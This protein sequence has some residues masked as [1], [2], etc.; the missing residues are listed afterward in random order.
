MEACEVFRLFVNKAVVV[1]AEPK[2]RGKP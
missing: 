2:R 1:V